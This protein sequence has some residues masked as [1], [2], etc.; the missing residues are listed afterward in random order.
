MSKNIIVPTNW[1]Q[2]NLEEPDPYDDIHPEDFPEL[3]NLTCS[4]TNSR[5]GCN[6]FRY[7][8]QIDRTDR[9]QFKKQCEQAHAREHPNCLGDMIIEEFD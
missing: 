9:K 8:L 1:E 4:C 7:E 2:I 6:F 5:I 3:I